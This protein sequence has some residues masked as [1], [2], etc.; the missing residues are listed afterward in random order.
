MIKIAP[1]H[2]DPDKFLY[3]YCSLP[4]LP[5]FLTKLQQ[6]IHSNEVGARKVSKLISTDAPMVAQI[7]KLVNSPYYSIPREI[8]NL[9]I[10]VAYL[11]LNEIY[12]VAMTLSAVKHLTGKNKIAFN[13]IW[14]HS[15]FTGMVANYLAKKFDPKLN[16]NELWSAAILHD[17]GKFVYLKFFPE[18]YN[19]LWDYSQD[20]KCLFS[21]AEKFY[22]LPS[23][24][25]LGTLLCNRWRLTK[26][27]K[28]VCSEHGFDELIKAEGNPSNDT[29]IP[30]VAAANLLTHLITDPLKEDIKEKITQTILKYFNIS[31]SKF[32]F[33]MTD[34]IEQKEKAQNLKI[35]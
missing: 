9:N 33:M 32:P 3:E 1:I 14:T 12:R 24:A 6:M 29:F 2:I 21:E 23:S 19:A 34:I 10:A 31:E 5:S 18:H 7:L 26:K 20:Q 22:D 27:V 11:G 30:M 17:L 4:E 13:E 8:T 28:E 35:F 15:V 25:Y 16:L